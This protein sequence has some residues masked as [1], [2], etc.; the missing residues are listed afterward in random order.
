M[1][2]RADDVVEVYPLLPADTWAWFCLD[3]VRYHGRTLTILWDRDGT[4]YH[5]GGGLVVL[6]DGKQLARAD[7]LKPLTAKL[8]PN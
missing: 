4:R 5:R 1:R 8:P 2:P 3:D 6:V 7:A